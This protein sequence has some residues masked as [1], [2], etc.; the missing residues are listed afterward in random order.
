V[1]PYFVLAAVVVLAL[2]CEDWQAR[3][4]DRER[5]HLLKEV[6]DG[7]TELGMTHLAHREQVAK[8]VA[9]HRA[10]VQ[11]LCQRIQAPEIA[12]M[13]HQIETAGPPE[14]T[15]PLTDA[16]SAERM[17]PIRAAVEEIER[18]ENE[19]AF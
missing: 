17:D 19:G 5:R 4:F 16:E 7:R 1:E 11:T 15:M 2:V 9:E 12:V 8:M 3:R 6:S 18:M 10:E 14:V 13:Q